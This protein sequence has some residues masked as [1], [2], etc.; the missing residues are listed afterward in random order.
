MAAII[1]E[2]DDPITEGLPGCYSGSTA[3]LDLARQRAARDGRPVLLVD[4]DGY[5]L[6]APDGGVEKYT[7]EVV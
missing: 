2:H 4:D 6:V 7:P 3:A 5:W 1:S